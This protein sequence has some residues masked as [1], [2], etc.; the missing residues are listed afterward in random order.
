MFETADILWVLLGQVFMLFM[1]LVQEW[2]G[3]V[4]AWMG[5]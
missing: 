4:L 3:I 2:L 1:P 5:F